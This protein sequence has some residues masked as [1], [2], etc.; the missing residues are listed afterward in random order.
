V[1]EIPR[2]ERWLFLVTPG[3][4]VTQELAPYRHLVQL[5]RDG[6]VPLPPTPVPS[7]VV[8]WISQGAF[9]PKAGIG[10]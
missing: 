5:V 4:P 3:R 7:G 10:E 8:A 2:Q 9:G 1:I 6:W